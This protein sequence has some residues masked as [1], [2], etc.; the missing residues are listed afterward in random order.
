MLT[1]PT[2]VSS[3]TLGPIL[4]AVHQPVQAALRP[5]GIFLTLEFTSRQVSDIHTQ[6]CTETLTLVD[7]EV[8]HVLLGAAGVPQSLNRPLENLLLL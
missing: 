2:F 5:F 4:M 8:L 6:I 3:H 7:Y 1:P